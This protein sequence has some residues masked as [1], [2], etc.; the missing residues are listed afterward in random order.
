MTQ[1]LSLIILGVWL[2][3]QVLK[4]GLLDKVGL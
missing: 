1:G 4:G 2:G 3:A